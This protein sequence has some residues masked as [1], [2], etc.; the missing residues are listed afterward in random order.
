LDTVLR[1]LSMVRDSC[2]AEPADTGSREDVVMLVNRLNQE[3]VAVYRRLSP[4]V[5]IE[6]LTAIVG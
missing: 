6:M 2:Y 4:T 1:K 3:G 5:L